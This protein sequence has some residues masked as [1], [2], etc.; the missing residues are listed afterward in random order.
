MMHEREKSGSSIVPRKPTNKAGKPAAEPV[1][2]REGAKGNA[3]RQ[4]TR[5][6]QG[7]GSVSQA[8]D[9]VRE[10]ARLDGKLQFT[11]LLHHVNVELLMESYRALK[12][13]A[14]D[15]LHVAITRGKV[16]WILDADIAGFFDS[17]S[18]DWLMRFVERRTKDRRLL[19]LIGKWLKAGI[20]EEGRVTHKREG[21][22]QGAVISPLLA[23][24]Y[25]HHVLDLWAHQWRQRHARGEVYIVRYADDFVAGF[26]YRDDAERFQAALTMR[27]KEF[28]LM[29][30]P[31]KTR[32]FEFGRFAASNRNKRGL[33]KPETFTFLGFTHI[34]AKS[35]NGKFQVRRKTRRKRMKAKLKEIK[36]D[37]RSRRHAPI[38]EQG[39]WLAQVVGGYFAYHAVPTNAPAL[40]AFR[41][42][43]K[44]LWLQSLRGRS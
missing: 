33:G 29:L 4:S 8:L 1:E 14:L 12:R 22:P 27:L 28:A 7:R 42:D 11:A 39:R 20:L 26:Q 32:L 15:A 30:H 18:H 16:S 13:G 24:I 40:A 34:C 38:A 25:L 19:R 37:L 21:T 44:R 10:A 31:D 41:F 36:E 35:R 43:V 23:N 17:L 3:G 6:T 9:R 5:R 2:G